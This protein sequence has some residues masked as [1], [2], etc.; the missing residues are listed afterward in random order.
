MPILP[1]RTK[2]IER[3]YD[4]MAVPMRVRPHADSAA[5]QAV[6]AAD[7]A[8]RRAGVQVRDLEELQDLLRASSLFDEVWEAGAE[9]HILPSNMARAL[10][11]SGSYIAGAFAGGEL[12]G[13]SLGFLGLREG[14]H[15]HSHLL[16][17]RRSAERAGVGFALK[18]HQRAWALAREVDVICWTFDPL[19]RRNAYFNLS[20]LGADLVAYEPNFYGA[21][22]D[23]VNA[24]DE[25]DRVLIR[26][27][28]ASERAIA[29]SEGR[30]KEPDVDALAA[31]GARVALD[32]G[33]DGAPV[34]ANDWGPTVLSRVP[35][36][37][38]SLRRSDPAR[39]SEWRKALRESL[40]RAMDQGYSVRGMTKSGWYVLDRAA[41]ASESN[42]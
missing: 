22:S 26:W 14:L 39:A 35:E 34:L 9:D 11:H 2:K 12:V 4:K 33:P 19:V 6:L 10:A 37:V 42:G 30:L 27:R 32:E 25:S 29:G 1:A 13:A 21:M 18:Q 7:A 16:A 31:A 28:L 40:G 24:G 36:D 15:L 3:P 17:V 41:G 5:E 38:V 8:A 23:G 20:K